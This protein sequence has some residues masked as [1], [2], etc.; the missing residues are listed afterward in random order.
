MFGA[1]DLVTSVMFWFVIIL[2]AFWTLDA[3]F[4]WLK[5]KVIAERNKL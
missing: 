4:H 3:G 2:V 5:D 1:L